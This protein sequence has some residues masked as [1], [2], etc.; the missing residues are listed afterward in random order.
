MIIKS[1][2]VRTGGTRFVVNYVQKMGEN[3]NI[4][5][6]DG[7]PSSFAEVDIMARL[8]GHKHAAI[9][10][11]ISPNRELGPAGLQLAID[12]IF[13]EMGLNED[14]PFILMKHTKLRKDG[15]TDAAHYHLVLPAA[16]NSGRVYNRWESKMRDEAIS[17]VCELRLGH[18]VVPGKH[19]TFVSKHLREQGRHEMAAEF[20]AVLAGDP[21]PRV[22]D[23]SDAMNHLLNRIGQDGLKDM[24]RS[25]V[26]DLQGKSTGEMASALCGLERQY[27]DIKFDFGNSHSRLVANLGGKF[28]VG[29]NR[30]LGVQKDKITQIIKLKEAYENGSN[31]QSTGRNPDPGSEDRGQ[32]RRHSGDAFGRRPRPGTVP[33]GGNAG[34][35]PRWPDA[36]KAIRNSNRRDIADDPQGNGRRQGGVGG[37]SRPRVNISERAVA[38]MA[39]RRA[40][41]R[42]PRDDQPTIRVSGSD[43]RAGS[44]FASS[45]RIE[46]LRA[47]LV[48]QGPRATIRPVNQ[49][50][51]DRAAVSLKARRP[52]LGGR[53]KL[54]ISHRDKIFGDR[55]AGCLTELRREHRQVMSTP[56]DLS[57]SSQPN[58]ILDLDDPMLM[59]KLSDQ[60]RASLGSW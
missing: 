9:H 49:L 43:L 32:G 60:L 20:E 52:F 4:E 45:P 53:G 33:A 16:D 8:S 57:S 30:L 17:R 2:M 5:F 35:D 41:L 46:K 26:Q 7:S 6:I 1:K 50:H 37:H 29:I 15:K 36:P 13:D 58:Q 11:T 23:Y 31:G 59:Q 48:M 44:K 40:R 10:Y 54:R 38:R 39:A 47:E 55:A 56:L 3:E 22:A 34:G 18:P 27:P 19:N 51:G 28:L 14:S 25:F 42:V 24:I 12:E 21:S